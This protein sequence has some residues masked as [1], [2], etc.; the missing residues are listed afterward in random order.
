MEVQRLKE[1]ALNQE[2]ETGK[3]VDHLVL[4]ELNQREKDLSALLENFQPNLNMFGSNVF[5]S[6]E[7]ALL[8]SQAEAGQTPD[9]VLMGSHLRTY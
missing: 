5:S 2:K 9:R 6:M 7:S 4:T 8:R 1:S 3:E